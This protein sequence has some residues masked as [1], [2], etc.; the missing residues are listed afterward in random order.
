MIPRFF[1]LPALKKMSLARLNTLAKNRNTVLLA[2]PGHSIKSKGRIVWSIFEQQ[3]KL[4]QQPKS[5]LKPTRK[6]V[7]QIKIIMDLEDYFTPL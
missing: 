1:S 6:K 3:R 2:M 5:T 4:C 7:K